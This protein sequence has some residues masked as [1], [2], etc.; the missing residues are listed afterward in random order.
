MIDDQQL[1]RPNETRLDYSLL[2]RNA[3]HR[4]DFLAALPLIEYSPGR[5]Q[6]ILRSERIGSFVYA[7]ICERHAPGTVIRSASVW[8]N[9]HAFEILVDTRPPIAAGWYFHHAELASRGRLA[10]VVTTNFDRLIEEALRSRGV[11]FNA[12]HDAPGFAA[13]AG[14]A[15]GDLGALPI[16]KIHGSIEDS[17]SL[18]DTL[19]Q[20]LAG[21]PPRVPRGR[22]LL[23]PDGPS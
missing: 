8:V 14:L 18:V 21:R 7:E 5:L 17:S 19:R 16:V 20:R 13:L 6:T 3:S 10:A 12:V 1:T 15:N 9:A 4:K 2:P 11:P 23:A 22:R